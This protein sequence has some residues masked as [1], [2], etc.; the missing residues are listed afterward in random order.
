MIDN[1]RSTVDRGLTILYLYI[2]CIDLKL[3]S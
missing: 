3:E 2:V 1:P